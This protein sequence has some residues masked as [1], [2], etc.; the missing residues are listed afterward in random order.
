MVEETASTL[1]FA[2]RMMKA[3][4]FFGLRVPVVFG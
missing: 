2:T 3:G 1:R 4:I